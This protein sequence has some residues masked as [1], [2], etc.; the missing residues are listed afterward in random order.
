MDVSYNQE[1]I[2]PVPP[3]VQT[4]EPIDRNNEHVPGEIIISE[5]G[6]L[7][8]KYFTFEGFSQDLIDGYNV[9]ITKILPQQIS[10]YHF[11]L[12]DESVAIF[13]RVHCALPY[14]TTSE[15]ENV[16]QTPYI[17]RLRGYTYSFSLYGDLQ[18]YL[19][20]KLV[21]EMPMFFLGK[22]PIMLG[23]VVCHLHGK[24]PIQKVQMGECGND[25]MGYFIIQSQSIGQERLGLIQENLRVNYIMKFLLTTKGESICR[26]TT[27]TFKGTNIITLMKNR[28]RNMEKV[29]DESIHISLMI[30]GSMTNINVFSVYRILGIGD[31]TEIFNMILQFVRPEWRKSVNLVLQPTL[32]AFYQIADDIEII[33]EKRHSQKLNYETRKQLL[34]ES[35]MEEL[36]PQMKGEPIRNKLHLLSIMIA[37]Y[38]EYLAGKAPLDDRDDWSNKKLET[39][40]TNLKKLFYQI[41]S[42]AVDITETNIR[43]SKT[44]QIDLSLVR[45]SYP[46]KYL[47]TEFIRNFK[48][49]DW[50]TKGMINY[51]SH[52]IEILK[53]ENM[54]DTYAHLRR[55]NT[56]V[57]RINKQPTVRIPHLS[58][59]G[60]IDP[61]DTPE[62]RNNGLIKNLSLT[63]TISIEHDNVVLREHITKGLK[64]EKT[65]NETAGCILNGIFLGWVDGRTMRQKLV[66]LRRTS[67]DWKN[68]SVVFNEGD[69]ILY[70]YNDE[71]RPMRPLL[72][73]E[74]GKLLIEEKKLTTADFPT[75]LREGV[76][77]YLDP[78][79]MR[80]TLVAE[81]LDSL[82]SVQLNYQENL[83]QLEEVE[84]NLNILT[85]ITPE[86]IERNRERLV[87][88]ISKGHDLNMSDL[89]KLNL[90][91]LRFHI[92]ETID[93]L[94]ETREQ[95]V[96]ALDQIRTRLH[97]YTHCELN[98]NAISGISASLTPL[99]EHNA[100]PRSIIQCGM[101][102]QALSVYHSNYRLR[103]D[104]SSKILSYPSRPLFETQ[105]HGLLGLNQ[106]PQGQT[107]IL[108]IMPYLGWNQ[109]DAIIFNR[110]SIDLGKFQ[111][112]AYHSYDAILIDTPEFTERFGR[113]SRPSPHYAMLDERG[114]IRLGTPIIELTEAESSHKKGRN[115]KQVRLLPG[116][117]II[118][119]IRTYLDTGEEINIPVR[120]GVGET[121][122][123]DKIYYGP[124]ADGKT[125][126]KVRIRDVRSPVGGDKFAIRPAQKATIGL[127]LPPEDMPRTHNGVTPDVLVSPHTI[128]SRATIGQI[129]EMVASKVSVLQGERVNATSF[130][131]FDIDK[132]RRTLK[133]YGY[134][135]WGT[136]AMYSGDRGKLLNASIFIGPCYYQALRHQ[137]KD[138]FQVRSKGHIDMVS[139]QPIRGR[140]RT[141]GI[142]LGHMERDALIAYGATEV[143]RERFV[144]SSNLHEA[145][146][147]QK[148]G[149]VA[150]PTLSNN[151]QFLRCKTCHEGEAFG[152]IEIRYSYKYL[153]QLLAGAGINMSFRVEALQHPP[154]PRRHPNI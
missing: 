49:T 151:Q 33:S 93:S 100:G 15:F 114:I 39:I 67:A 125:V 11:Q 92:D 3:I 101:I 154:Q 20:G 123:L 111:T 12:P 120:L 25:P 124:N 35:L 53:R 106:F 99:L 32:V 74:E 121:G 75:L 45:R 64:D 137:V 103:F 133:D 88:I 37:R 122:I 147:C 4:I 38:A 71:S 48:A 10:S 41:M 153:V 28:E 77:E 98:P 136:E 150:I 65:P 23:S 138:K 96:Q 17:S 90:E 84:L 19:H 83:Q 152:K 134:S 40:G 126:V 16:P 91:D 102:K 135:Q 72:I 14:I 146:F 43:K 36:F 30:L 13:K 87:T 109:D 143:L 44:P 62:G 113:P 51:Q 105:I 112:V 89:G 139:R 50:G 108:A 104:T 24:T 59:I 42:N 63:A 52:I 148:C 27:S 73:V 80:N 46:D 68:L 97:R 129:F 66:K 8:K 110:A 61:A 18:R 115:Y 21:E 31:H 86:N 70:V 130:E 2:L 95:I 145:V 116:D 76:I 22:I 56:P 1:D 128:P 132:F 81:S 55:I 6:E 26:M 79:E 47:T 69:D 9:W 34:T 85:S 60:F 58:Q 54:T 131:S 7:L 29:K 82:R 94:K 144:V 119:K 127:I 57:D 142:R 140:K 118:N 78:L 107:I 141:G 117:V 149:S 5:Q